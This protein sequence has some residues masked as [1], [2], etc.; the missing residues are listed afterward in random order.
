MSVKITGF[1]TLQKELAELQRAMASL[2]GEVAQLHFTPGDPASVQRA[3]EEMEAAVDR[4]AA[5]YS[6][7]PTVVKI[8]EGSKEAFRKRILETKEG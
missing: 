3:I 2:D 7:N 6:S 5:S 8:A 4:K 1:D